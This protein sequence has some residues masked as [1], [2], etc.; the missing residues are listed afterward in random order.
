MTHPAKPV[1]DGRVVV[2]LDGS[3]SAWAALERAVAEARRRHATLEIVHAW[4]WA[5]TDPLAFRPGQRTAA[6]R[7]GDRQD[8]AATGRV[9]AQS[10]S[11]LPPPPSPLRSAGTPR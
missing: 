7:G 1:R 11:Q 3:D 9:A 2:G 8:R 4:P 10:M 5:R 6:A